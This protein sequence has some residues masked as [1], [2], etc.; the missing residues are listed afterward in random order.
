MCS[1]CRQS[2]GR[3]YNVHTFRVRSLCVVN[4]QIFRMGELMSVITVDR[5]LKI[6]R[7]FHH[8]K[9]G[10]CCAHSVKYVIRRLLFFS[11]LKKKAACSNGQIIPELGLRCSTLKTLIY[12]T[13]CRDFSWR[14]FCIRINVCHLSTT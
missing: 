8:H 9:K 10:A 3:L 7:P 13:W 12:R 1:A 2:H 14:R 11:F 4:E 6:F 5:M